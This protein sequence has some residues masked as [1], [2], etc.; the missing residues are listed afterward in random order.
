MSHDFCIWWVL[1]SPWKMKTNTESGVRWR[2]RMRRGRRGRR[3]AGGAAGLGTTR[4][5][6][7]TG[8]MLK[9]G[10]NWGFFSPAQLKHDQKWPQ[11]T[12]RG[13]LPDQERS[14]D[15]FYPD[16]ESKKKEWQELRKH[17]YYLSGLFWSQNADFKEF[18]L[19]DQR[20]KL[21]NLRHN[22]LQKKEEML[23]YYT[24]LYI[25]ER[26]SSTDRK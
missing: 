12:F 15:S 22:K 5:G 16:S 23:E 14:S 8:K 4:K 24:S 17:G 6:S 3:P 21:K 18:Y 13:H 10:R 1:E 25:R 7:T 19:L 20:K 26:N 9:S 2:V 11:N